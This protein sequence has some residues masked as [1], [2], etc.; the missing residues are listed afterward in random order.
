MLRGPGSRKE[1]NIGGKVGLAGKDE[2]LTKVNNTWRTVAVIHCEG[3]KSVIEIKYQAVKKI[4][5]I[6]NGTIL[7]KHLALTGK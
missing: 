1:H 5:T 4:V 7:S 2:S 3:V 6:L